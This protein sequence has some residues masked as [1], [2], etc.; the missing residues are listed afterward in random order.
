MTTHSTAITHAAERDIVVSVAFHSSILPNHNAV[1]V[2]E[3]IQATGKP[4]QLVSVQDDGVH[5]TPPFVTKA[6]DEPTF[7]ASAVHTPV[8]GVI[9]AQVVKSAS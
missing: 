7:I 3:V 5:N 9:P 2:D 4:V 6:Q 8:H 1:E